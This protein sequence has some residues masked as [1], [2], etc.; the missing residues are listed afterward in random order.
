MITK[1]N[2]IFTITLAT[3]S[4]IKYYIITSHD[5]FNI[6]RKQ[7]NKHYSHEEQERYREMVNT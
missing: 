1:N 7:F 6:Y 2:P 4:N 5:C 3:I